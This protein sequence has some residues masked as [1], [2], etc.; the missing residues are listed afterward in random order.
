MRELQT[1]SRCSVG[2]DNDG[3]GNCSICAV[4]PDKVATHLS[5]LHN[6][7]VHRALHIYRDT[8]LAEMRRATD[9]AME[10]ANKFA[11]T[12]VTHTVNVRSVCR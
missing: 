7:R 1:C 12:S 9:I 10:S 8:A 2:Y 5:F 6:L 11:Q 4:L 3:D